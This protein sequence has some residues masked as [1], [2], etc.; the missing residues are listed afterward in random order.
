MS[1]LHTIGMSSTDIPTDGTTDH[2]QPAA[3]SHLTSFAGGIAESAPSP[4]RLLTLPHRWSELLDRALEVALSTAPEGE[5]ADAVGRAWRR[6]AETNPTLHA[7]LAQH[8]HAP[9]VSPELRA[10]HERDLR[11]IA[12]AARMGEASDPTEELVRIGAT[13]LAM[14]GYPAT[15]RQRP[16]PAAVTDR[17]Q[18]TLTMV[19]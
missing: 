12:L 13:M 3:E 6:T 14:T 7:V 15:P 1:M 11:T 16:S 9:R 17:S 4:E 2:Q 19:H 8:L 10:R 18:N 5:E